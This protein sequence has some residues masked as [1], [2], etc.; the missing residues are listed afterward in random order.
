MTQ[1]ELKKLTF[2]EAMKLLEEN[3][4]K[5]E[6]N[7]FPLDESIKLYEEGIALSKHLSS[8]LEAAE[9]KVVLLSEKEKEE[10]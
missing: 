7:D 1:A 6:N 5:L 9:K 2:E 3:V 10:E 8:L 4:G